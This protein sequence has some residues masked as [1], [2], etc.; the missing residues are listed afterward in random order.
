MTERGEGR[1][2]EGAQVTEREGGLG[3][4]RTMCDREGGGDWEREGA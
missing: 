3:E 1:G 2:R 4:R